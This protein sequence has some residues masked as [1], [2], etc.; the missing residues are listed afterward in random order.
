MDFSNLSDHD[1]IL[2]SPGPRPLGLV[3]VACGNAETAGLSSDDLGGLTEAEAVRECVQ[4]AERAILQQLGDTYMLHADGSFP[5]WNGGQHYQAPIRY[6]GVVGHYVQR[7]DEIDD[8][9]ADPT[10]PAEWSPGDWG[11]VAADEVPKAARL[12]AERIVL[13][14]AEAYDN[15]AMRLQER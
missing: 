15:E 12:G 2:L 1:V 10:D 13:E 9:A 7:A 3:V 6:H 5:A 14:A 8:E 11:W 4:A